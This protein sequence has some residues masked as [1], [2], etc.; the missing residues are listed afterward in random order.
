MMQKVLIHPNPIKF[1]ALQVTEDLIGLLLGFGYE[2]MMRNSIKPLLY[3]ELNRDVVHRVRFVEDNVAFSLCDFVIVVGG[4]GTLLKIANQ[5]AEHNKPILG[6]NMGTIGFMTEVE[7]DELPIVARI[8]E[9]NYELDPRIMLD[10]SV[11]DSYGNTTFS[12]TVLN[13]VVITKGVISKVIRLAISVNDRESMRFSGDGVIVC[14]PTGSTAYSLAA[15]GPI[16]GPSCDCMAVT[17]ICPHALNAKSFV[18]SADTEITITPE[19]R[20][21]RVF[22][23]PD[24]FQSYELQMGDKVHIK[25]SARSISLIHLKGQGFYEVIS[26]KLSK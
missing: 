18:V 7:V 8:K 4:D 13:E 19:H 6:V 22:L 15:G 11:Q 26:E 16:L 5:A 20:N 3:S 21:Q 23:S 2:V 14:T 9:G 1:N 10:I 24:G 25:K 17:P 12:T